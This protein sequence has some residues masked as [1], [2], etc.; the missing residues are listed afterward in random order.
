M[1]SKKSKKQV[2]SKTVDPNGEKITTPR[3]AKIVLFVFGVG[4]VLTFAELSPQL[5]PRLNMITAAG[6]NIKMGDILP[7]FRLLI[8]GKKSGPSMFEIA[9]FIGKKECLER[10]TNGIKKA[11][12]TT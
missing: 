3:T 11:T 2:S 12:Q 1:S 8:T 5:T 9:S 4:P 7:L 6:W 10:I